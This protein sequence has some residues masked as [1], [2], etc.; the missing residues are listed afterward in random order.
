MLIEFSDTF[1]LPRFSPSHSCLTGS[2]VLEGIF[3][4]LNPVQNVDNLM[5][6]QIGQRCMAQPAALPFSHSTGCSHQPVVP[7][8]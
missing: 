3:L 6:V 8:H 5:S 4:A 2:K 1:S 7:T